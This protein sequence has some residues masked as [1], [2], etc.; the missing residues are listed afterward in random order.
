MGGGD[1]VSIHDLA[2]A[3]SLHDL[4]AGPSGKPVCGKCGK[5][6]SE[7][8]ARRFARLPVRCLSTFRG[9]QRA[10]SDG[11]SGPHEFV[12]AF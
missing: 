6:A 8:A 5:Q 2:C 7:D 12:E 10:H 4:I 11:H 9:V 1:A 3:H